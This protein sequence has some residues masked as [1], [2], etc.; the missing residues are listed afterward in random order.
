MGYSNDRE[1]HDALGDEAANLI[2]E[3]PGSK[4]ASE[5]VLRCAHYDTVFSTPGGDDNASAMAVMLEVS[6]LLREHTGGRTVCY[7]AFAC[8]EPPYCNVDALG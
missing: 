3:Q 2:V 1:C 8:E 5:I 4:P 7:V 6:R